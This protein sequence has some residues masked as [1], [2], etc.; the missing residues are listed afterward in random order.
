MKLRERQRSI[1]EA[2]L[3]EGIDATCRR[4]ERVGGR[5]S[6]LCIADDERSTVMNV[7]ST[8][9][10]PFPAASI[11]KLA[12]V[13]FL[14]AQGHRSDEKV[15]LPAAT[16][17]HAGPGYFDRHQYESATIGAVVHDMTMWSGNRA[18]LVAKLR[19]DEI[20]E[21]LKGEGFGHT[22]LERHSDGTF[23]FGQT[24]AQ[25]ALGLV[26]RIRMSTD[27]LAMIAREGLK[28][29]MW[30]LV[31]A[32]L[33]GSDCEFGSKTGALNRSSEHH[34]L[35]HDVGW[36]KAQNGKEIRYAILTETPRWPMKEMVK[37]ELAKLGL[38][39]AGY[40]SSPD[41]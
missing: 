16:K 25:E 2:A 19:V 28:G 41:D 18:A 13:N 5:V 24:T 14:I 38:L 30:K 3:H 11:N 32:E 31:G 15:T 8:Y 22:Y 29:N 26:D 33:H 9:C 12:I 40:V 39:M 6:V 7:E 21:F 36:L 37:K 23:S 35:R 17:G 27:E 20:N 34:Y 1:R 10:Q 4:I